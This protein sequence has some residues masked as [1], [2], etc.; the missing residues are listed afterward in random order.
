MAPAEEVT[1]TVN[2]Y[3]VKEDRYLSAGDTLVIDGVTM[4]FFT[5]SEKENH[6]AA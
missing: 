3:P 2:D 6:D 5:G 1:I 4:T